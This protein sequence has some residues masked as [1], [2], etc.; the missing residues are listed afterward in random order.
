MKVEGK[1][2]KRWKKGMRSGRTIGNHVRRKMKGTEKRGK[3]KSGMVILF[4]D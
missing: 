4:N 2:E 3:A 1:G